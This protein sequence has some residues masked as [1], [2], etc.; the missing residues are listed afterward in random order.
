[1]SRNY[2]R[3]FPT[4]TKRAPLEIGHTVGPWLLLNGPTV[5]PFYKERRRSC[6][7]CRCTGCGAELRA[8]DFALKAI[9]DTPVLP[10]PYKTCNTC[11]RQRR[12]CAS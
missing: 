2:V 8:P 5:M 11:E 10:N 4:N 7:W 12:A 1:M 3:L 6:W 9:R